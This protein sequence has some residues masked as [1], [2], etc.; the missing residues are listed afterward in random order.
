M[1]EQSFTVL[2]V[3]KGGKGPV[4]FSVSVK[5]VFLIA[6]L[7]IISLAGIGGMYKTN[8]R[9][10][11]VAAQ[12]PEV[13]V[14]NNRLLS[15]M[16]YLENELNNLL[17]KMAELEMLG[18]EVRGIVSEVGPEDVSSGVSGHLP[19]KLQDT[20]E[21]LYYLKEEIPQKADELELLLEEM[22]SYRD[23]LDVTPD[24]WPV[25]GR[26]TSPFGMRPSP[27][28]RRTTFH[29][30]I[31]IGASSGVPV[32]AAAS[33][34]V[35][36][37]RYQGAYGNYIIIDHGTYTTHYAHLRRFQISADDVVEKGQLIG[38]VGSTGRSTGPHLHFEIHK[39]GVP[40]NPLEM[41]K[42]EVSGYGT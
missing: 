23:E 41:L 15:E 4:S 13:T 40:F 38:E 25:E 20:G 30:G 37:A 19:E 14:E 26:I 33:G 39:K 10:S 17:G 24:F 1:K 5:A 27:F 32:R 9:L 35:V 21:A 2:I 3:S 36:Q 29:S 18:R 8:H 22:V 34:K 42:P 12:M 11:A 16:D 31:D 6:S 28:T 7:F